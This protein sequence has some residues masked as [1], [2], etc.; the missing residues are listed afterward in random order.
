MGKM[1]FKSFVL[2]QLIPNTH[3]TIYF[4]AINFISTFILLSNKMFFDKNISLG[5]DFG[6]KGE[7][8]KIFHFN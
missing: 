4:D 7:G 1:V 8:T 6:G 5:D 3:F 2:T